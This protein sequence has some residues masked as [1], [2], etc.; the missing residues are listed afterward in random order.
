LKRRARLSPSLDVHFH[1]VELS[2]ASM[3]TGDVHWSR[4]SLLC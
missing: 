1:A 3:R 4:Q 2:G